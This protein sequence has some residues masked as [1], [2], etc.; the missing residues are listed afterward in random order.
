MD[1]E[2]GRVHERLTDLITRHTASQARRIEAESLHEQGVGRDRRSLPL[3]VN[4]ALL[5]SLLEELSEARANR[6]ELGSRF[7]DEFPDVRKA[8]ARVER[9]SADIVEQE[10]RILAGVRS[11]FERTVDSEQ[12]LAEEVGRQRLVVAAYEEK[13]ID[14]KIKNREVDPPC[15]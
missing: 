1:Q 6:A 9:L 2:A 10:D 7:T 4:N 12:K 5:K 15:G 11:D 3:L 13:A 8:D 14:F